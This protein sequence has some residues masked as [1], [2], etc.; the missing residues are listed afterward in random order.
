MKPKLQKSSWICKLSFYNVN[1]DKTFT[2]IL[3][4]T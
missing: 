3:V 4:M 1:H 2:F